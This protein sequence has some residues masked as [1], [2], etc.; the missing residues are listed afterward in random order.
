MLLDAYEASGLSGPQFAVQH[1]VKYQT[2]ATWLPTRKRQ[3]GGYPRLPEPEATTLVLAEVEGFDGGRADVPAL[4]IGL[5]GG[6]VMSLRHAG[7]AALAAELL[8]CLAG[9]ARC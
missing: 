2:F 1:G 8:K 5:P 4:E 7:Q 9:G 3:R 6:A